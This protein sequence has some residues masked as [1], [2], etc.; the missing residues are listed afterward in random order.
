MKSKA[1]RMIDK[2]AVEN[3][4][5]KY[6]RVTSEKDYNE[7]ATKDG[8]IKPLFTA[9]GWDFTNLDEVSPEDK[10]SKKRVD[11][12]LK[13]EGIPKFFLEAKPLHE[14]LDGYRTVNGEK[15]SYVEQ[16]VNY[17]Y[18]RG[19]DWAIL[20]NFKEIRVYDAG[21]KANP[22]A[23]F[24]F[25]LR[26]NDFL[27]DYEN[28]LYLL[29]KE[30]F[31]KGLLDKKY[32]TKARKRPIT[33]QLLSDFTT[34]RDILSKDVYKLNK[35]KNLNEEDLDEAVQRLFDRLIF[36]RNC[37]D[38]GLEA[39]ELLSTLRQWEISKKNTLIGRV[40]NLF[41]YYDENYDSTIF[42]TKRGYLWD[43]ID[44]GD[45]ALSKIISG[46]YVTED[47]AI[48]YDFSLIDAN[49]L[50]NIYEQYLGHILKKTEKR[51]KL[52]ES[53]AKRKEEGI[54]YTPSFVVDYIIKNTVGAFIKTR[55]QGAHK[56]KVLDPACGSGSFLIRAF[57]I[58]NE[59]HSGKEGYEQSKLDT[60][61]IGTTYSSKLNILKDNIFGVDLDKQA[62]DIAQLNL[63][64]KVS[65]KKKRLPILQQNI[66]N[67]NS[68]IADS[69]IAGSKAFKWDDEFRGISEDG[70]FDIIVGNPPY[71]RLEKIPKNE[72]PY[73][74]N[75]YE[76][77]PGRFDLY[78]LFIEK[79]INLLKEEGYLGF[80][81][82]N[83]LLNNDDFEALRKFI[84][85]TCRIKKIVLLG[86]GVFQQATVSTIILIL[87]KEITHSNNMV[88]WVIGKKPES[89][90]ELRTIRQA[91]FYN[92][93]KYRF[94]IKEKGVGSIL[95]KCYKNSIKFED[96][97]DYISGIQVW[98]NESDRIKHPDLL[99]KKPSNNLY[100]KT[101]VG[102]NIDKYSFT[103]AGDYVLYDR[104]LLE[105]ARA[106]EWFEKKEKL[107]MRYIGTKL[108]AA[109]DDAQYY[110]Q[111]SVIVLYPKNNSILDIKY[112]LAI[113]NSNLF[114]FLYNQKVGKNPYPRIN[115]S[116]LLTLPFKKSELK[117][118]KEIIVVVDSLIALKRK[119]NQ[120]KQL[121]S[122]SEKLNKDVEF[123]EEKINHLVYKIYGLSKKEIEV[124]E[125]STSAY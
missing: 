46:L 125:N 54:Y 41:E 105:R 34:F 51:T 96:A 30:A 85:D 71:V 81:V 7:E 25:V 17:A 118:Q 9:L 80:I 93:E 57:D 97:V 47:N 123:L 116:Y 56:I 49:V 124:I 39:P 88:D 3:L 99:T 115:L 112:I 94:T 1:G 92:N 33:E 120:T 103:F 78:S 110:A 29:S 24:K 66:K 11:Y 69:N 10:V 44:V 27:N 87:Q 106:P 104:K 89:P 52:T 62:V 35:D 76:T 59:Y 14:S 8:F 95:D 32:G 65:E 36:I 60:S 19:C 75:N 98:Q 83:T 117:D 79:G 119:E 40:R 53:R 37:E 109:Y 5:K 43:K 100:K 61:G 45:N 73:Y 20:T 67:G 21:L 13:L 23:S 55:K 12:A 108:I 15:V 113:I 22:L 64:L 114:Q 28:W 84:L 68:L 16:A 77:V 122:N 42:D 74:K 86:E 82:P 18:Y 48:S 50:G 26:V 107:V 90:N 102:E 101:L 70:K 2:Q 72:R 31:Q 63:L 111:K 91:D 4:I 6:E 38:R 58:L 121:T